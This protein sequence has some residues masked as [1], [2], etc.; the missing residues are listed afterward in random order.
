MSIFRI[1]WLGQLLS[2]IGSSITNFGLNI[3]ILKQTG[4]ASQ[5]A[6]IILSSTIPSIIFSPLAGTLVDRWDRRKT[7]ISAHICRAL[8]TLVLFFIV[9]TTDIQLWYIYLLN[10][11]VSIIGAFNNPAYKAAI[12]S[13]VSEK[14]LPQAS[15]MVQLSFSL[16]QIIS[17]LIA[18]LL[19]ELIHLQG[20]VII[21]FLGLLIALT[22][23]ILVK[24]GEKIDHNQEDNWE[25]NQSPS[26]WQEIIGGWTYLRERPGL[27]NFVVFL[28][29]YQFLI[30]F[31]NVLFYPLVLTIT[32]PPELG[33]IIFLSGI[34][35]LLGSIFMSNW[36]YSWENLITTVL[37]AMSLSGIWIAIGGSRPSLIQVYIGT[38]LFF[39]THTF[40]NG[41]VQL[42]IQTKVNESFQGRVFAL[43][44]TVSASAT[45]L[46]SIIAA[47]LSDFVF[48][49]LMAFDGPWS[50]LLVGQLIGSGPGRGTG[51]LFVI[52]GCFILIT[53]I[54]ASQYPAFRKLEGKAQ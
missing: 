17:P 23:L 7:M 45:P 32:T 40:V 1:I 38:I 43:T 41:L 16:Q 11:F 42:I 52:V 33:K 27:I 50:K 44:G 36:K 35:M 53:A 21:D 22:I 46:A 24:F 4:S 15:G 47:P 48:E 29:V 20:I 30:G 39:I 8:L 3:F 12:T 2:L 10:I 14:D 13:L 49:P 28:T 19:L 34:G 9:T 25:L 31:V 51:F 37:V 6:L 18:G 26:L 5:F 54:I